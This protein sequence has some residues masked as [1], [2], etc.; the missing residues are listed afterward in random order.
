MSIDWDMVVKTLEEVGNTSSTKS[1]VEVLKANDCELLRNIVYAALSD[2][3]YFMTTIPEYNREA[4]HYPTDYSFFGL[5][6]KLSSRQLSGNEAKARVAL[7]LSYIYV[8]YANVMENVIKK[9]LRIGLNKGLANKAFGKDFLPKQPCMLAK[10]YNEK[11]L[12]NI[13]YPATIQQKM[14]GARCTLTVMNGQMQKCQTRNGK[15]IHI[16][17]FEGLSSSYDDYVLDGELLHYTDGVLDDRKTGNGFINSALTTPT[18]DPNFKLVIWDMIPWEVFYGH[19]KSTWQYDVRWK[20]LEAVVKDANNVEVVPSESINSLEEAMKIF[21][22]NLSL[23]YEGAILKNSNHLWTN[24]R[25]PDLVKMK[26]EITAEFNVIDIVEGTGKYK[27]MLGSIVVTDESGNI[28]TNVGT[29]FSDEERQQ[30]WKN[31]NTILNQIVEVKYNEI[32]ET[33]GSNKKSLFLPVY[34]VVRLDKDSADN[35]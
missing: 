12:N 14:D 32:I 34:I 4:N 29:G 11:N 2:D 26:E 33:K 13:E 19:K 35:L 31:K 22:L 27:N 15:T 17:Y 3:K 18:D 21:A 23:G 8:K 28:K 10:S 9:D 20:M 1:K 30:Y 7:H 5:L 6:D 24:K 16:P 25:S